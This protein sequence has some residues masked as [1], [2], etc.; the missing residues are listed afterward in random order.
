M[1]ICDPESVGFGTQVINK[2]GKC[3]FEVVWYSKFA[4]PVCLKSDL[5]IVSEGMC[6]I[7]NKKV[8]SYQKNSTAKCLWLQNDI[9]GSIY[10][11]ELP[12]SE[13]SLYFNK[14][15]SVVECNIH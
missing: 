8:V 2:A 15:S 5:V 1:A 3:S 6:S 12:E 13:R 11:S 4:C 9:K 10:S 14:H 7:K